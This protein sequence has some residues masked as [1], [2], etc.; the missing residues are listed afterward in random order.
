[1]VNIMAVKSCVISAVFS[2]IL[3]LTKELLIFLTL[4]I[5][6]LNLWS[7]FSHAFQLLNTIL[8]I[9]IILKGKIFLHKPINTIC[10]IIFNFA[11]EKQ[12]SHIL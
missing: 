3:K 4:D 7:S 2:K 11:A 12:I 1:M 10:A 5:F 8:L 6:P 9:A